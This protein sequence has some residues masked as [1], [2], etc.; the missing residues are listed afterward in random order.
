MN[1]NEMKSVLGT[2]MLS[3]FFNKKNNKQQ[4]EAEGSGSYPGSK[5]SFQEGS[6]GEFNSIK[7]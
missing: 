1:L 4:T 6:G 7:F 2:K 5:K 3:A